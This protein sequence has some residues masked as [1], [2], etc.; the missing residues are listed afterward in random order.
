M[1]NNHKFRKARTR[2]LIQ[3]GGLVEKSGLLD[4]LSISLGQDLQRDNALRDE[5]LVLLGALSS[6]EEEM[7]RGDY[8]RN[9]W[10][11]RGISIIK[12]KDWQ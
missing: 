7:G 10:K 11:E 6:L 5:V 12:E 3:I 1:S 4:R 9:L 2:T 8:S